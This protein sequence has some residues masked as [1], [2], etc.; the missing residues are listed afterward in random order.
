MNCKKG[1]IAFV[2][3]EN[4][5]HPESLNGM[6]VEVL[7]A[8][9]IGRYRLPDGFMAS[10]GPNAWVIKFQR[11]IT[12]RI[13]GGTRKTLYAGCPDANLRP[14]RDPGDDATDE[15]LAWKPVPADAAVSASAERVEA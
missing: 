3:G 10:G 14:I 5:L 11:P 6:L 12:V 2:V 15:T 8:S 4:R 13:V 9:P 7:H 1:D